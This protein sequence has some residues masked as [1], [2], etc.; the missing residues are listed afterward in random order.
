MRID[1]ESWP[2]LS[3][4]LDEWLDLPEESRPPWLETLGPEHATVLPMFRELVFARANAGA[5]EF[6]ETLPRFPQTKATLESDEGGPDSATGALIGRY[7][8]L[9]E[10]GRGGMGVVWVAERSDG[11]VKRP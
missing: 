8:L 3:K 7:R 1:P 2:S 10:L 4:L 5:E 6:L 9:R 11:E